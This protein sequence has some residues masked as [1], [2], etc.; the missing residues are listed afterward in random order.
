M[1]ARSRPAGASAPDLVFSCRDALGR[2]L[3]ASAGRPSA[4]S[5]RISLEL[6]PRRVPDHRRALGHRQDHAAAPA[7]RADAEHAA[8][9]S[10]STA[11]R[12]RARR[13]TSSSSSRTIPTRCCNGARSRATSPSA[14]KA[15]CRASE[16]DGAGRRCAAARAARRARRRPS[17]AAVRRHAA[18]RPDRARAGAAAGR[19]A[20]GRAVR[21]ARRHDQGGAAGR[22]PSRCARRPARASCS[23]PTTSRRRSISATASP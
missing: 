23:S 19:P 11:V 12:S 9:P 4:H 17:L 10:T 8:A 13:P 22:A 3:R 5:R 2:S 15:G 20:D 1:P 18:T 6:A 14:W 21:G 7:R 16:I